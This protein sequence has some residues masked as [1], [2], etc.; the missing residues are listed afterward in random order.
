MQES[1]NFLVTSMAPELLGPTCSSESLQA[2]TDKV[3]GISGDIS[4]P[5]LGMKKEVY[6]ELLDK[7]DVVIHGAANVNYLLPYLGRI[8]SSLLRVYMVK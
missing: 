4:L 6:A 8:N 5:N 7:V 3:V 1:A 2:L